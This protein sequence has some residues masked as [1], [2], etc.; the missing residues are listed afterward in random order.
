MLSSGNGYASHLLSLLHYAISISDTLP[1]FP[2]A[3]GAPPDSSIRPQDAT[4]ATL[5]S[6]VGAEFY[7]KVKIGH[8]EGARDGWI[9][10][11]DQEVRWEVT[12][13]SD[14]DGP[15]LP[16]GWRAIGQVTDVPHDL[17]ESLASRALDDVKNKNISASTI[18][19]DPPT[20]PGILH[21][22][23]RYTRWYPKELP[24]KGEIQN[25]YINESTSPAS[26]VVLVP[27]Y[28][29]DEP[30]T[31]V[32][33]LLGVPSVDP[34]HLESTYDLLTALAQW[35]RCQKV[36]VW[37]VPDE[38]TKIWKAKSD[39]KVQVVKRDEHLGAMVWYGKEE[40]E[41]V[42]AIGGE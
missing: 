22:I 3:W 35:Y 13:S 42:K 20:S 28:T 38:V 9:V 41:D 34:Q 8:G 24:F 2:S 15:A 12:P 21:W 5:W 19:Y 7:R 31:L 32:V 17:L 27:S 25:A 30:P 16:D 37:Q 6:D 23:R 36:E 33:S 14:T 26:L 40:V 11:F 4:F 10:N 29:P 1:P 39:A 18:V